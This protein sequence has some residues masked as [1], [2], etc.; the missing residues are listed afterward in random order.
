MLYSLY[1]RNFAL[2]RELSIEFQPGL[3]IITGET[4]AGKSILVGA[5]GLVLGERASSDMVRSDTGKAVIE[6]VMKGIH[7]EKI[8]P[9]LKD[10]EIETAPELI[11][12]RELSATGQ[13]RCFINDTPCTVALLK[14]IGEL[15]IDLHGQHEHQLLL[16]ADTH[17]AMLDDFAG[18]APEI[19]VYNKARSD[20]SGLKTQLRSIEQESTAI[21][22]KK[23]L[24]EFQFNELSALDPKE[25]EEE[26]LDNEITLLEN[27]ENLF[28]LC[29]IL[30]DLL[31]DSDQSVYTGMT[32]ALHTLEKLVNIDKRFEPHI[33]EIQGARSSLDELYRFTGRYVAGIDFNA[34]RLEELRERQLQLQRMCRKYALTVSGLVE[35]RKELEERLVLEENLDEKTARIKEEISFRKVELSRLALSLSEKRRNAAM[36][37]ESVVRHHLAELGIPNASFVVSMTNEINPD[38]DI[39]TDGNTFTAFENGYDRIEFLIS[40]NPGEKPKPLV[41]VA[42]GGE[43]SRVMLAMKS[44]LAE[45]AR[46]PILIFDEI[47]TGISGR[48]AEAVGKS[49]KKLSRVHQIIAITHLPQIAAMAD[50]HLS[51]QKSVKDERTETEVTALDRENRLQAIAGLFSGNNISPASLN[52]AG[53]LLE[54]AGSV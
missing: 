53:E 24:L 35:L 2:I 1:V 50:L 40:A 31:Y 45:S 4:G 26:S 33:E 48:V 8:E 52:L 6:A 46:L 22:A 44:A 14:Q 34:E 41:K 49:L 9:L 7:A 27:A 28:S 18:T 32:A 10:A 13:S 5:L 17:E 43:I 15:L 42:S 54:R 11:I 39:I 25:V 36:K 19:L 23:E 51:V 29:T 3:T 20:L 16:H 30:T 38:G 47:D 37:L 12:R 21:Q